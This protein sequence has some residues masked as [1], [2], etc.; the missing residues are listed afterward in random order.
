MADKKETGGPAFPMHYE[1]TEKS[2]MVVSYDGMTL[3]DYFAGQVLADS[4]GDYQTDVEAI[5]RQAYYLADAMIKER[6]K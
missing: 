2:E 1:V 5:A 6:N 4:G 3:R